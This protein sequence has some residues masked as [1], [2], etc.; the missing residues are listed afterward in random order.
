M[1]IVLRPASM[2]HVLNALQVI[3]TVLLFIVAQNS[4]HCVKIA[5]CQM[6]YV[7]RATKA[8]N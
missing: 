4:T 6:D 7:H 3:I 5:T 2:E 8:I 1:F